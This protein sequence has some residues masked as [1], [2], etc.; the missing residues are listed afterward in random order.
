MLYWLNSH[1]SY[2]HWLCVRCP[3][4]N[5]VTARKEKYSKNI[6]FNIITICAGAHT[7]SFAELKI[8]SPLPPANKKR[9]HITHL[10][11]DQLTTCNPGTP[12]VIVTNKHTLMLQPINHPREP[13]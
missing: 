5:F 3:F 12:D 9:K 11:P 6:R 2:Y 13:S 7:G 8:F 1:K 10:L 4:I